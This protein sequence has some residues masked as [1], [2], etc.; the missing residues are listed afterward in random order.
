ML[1][2][3]LTELEIAA[4]F[5]DEVEA[6]RARV[7]VGAECTAPR[8]T[9][10]P[11]RRSATAARA[12]CGRSAA[13]SC[14]RTSASRR[15]TTP[16]TSSASGTSSR[17]ARPRRRRTSSKAWD[18]VWAAVD[19]G[20]EALRPGAVGWKVDEAAR[21]HLVAAG[22]PEPMYSLGHQ[23]GRS[24]HDGGTLLGPRWD[25][26]GQAPLRPRRGGE[27]VH[28]RVRH[29]GP[30]PRLRRARGGRRS[31]RPTASSGCR[32]RSASSGSCASR[33][34]PRSARASP[35]SAPGAR[36]RTATSR[37]CTG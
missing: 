3:D 12:S 28:A 30:G 21:S 29:R 33:L 11:T 20:A 13:S 36:R 6:A 26:Y 5:H 25:R 35:T 34:A 1:A 27:R 9:R 18:A 23:L 2:P 31:S 14:T 16:A 17:R 24:A 10:A 19:A 37:L 4:A 7:R 22:F 32:R 15:R 8:S